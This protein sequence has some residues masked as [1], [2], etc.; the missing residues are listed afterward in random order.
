M[1]KSAK[2][3][4][5]DELCRKCDGTGKLPQF[6]HIEGGK[7]FECGGTGE[8]QQL[9][10]WRA[11]WRARWSAMMDDPARRAQVFAPVLTEPTVSV[12]HRG[13]GGGELYVSWLNLETE[14]AAK[15]RRALLALPDA[16]D[17]N[18]WVTVPATQR[19]ALWGT[20]KRHAAGVNLRVG[21]QAKGAL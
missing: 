12:N 8:R 1:T 15:L 11:E 2:D 18:L 20:L 17:A 19:R 21:M 5:L 16:V 9:A 6:N 13:H 14:V 4:G 7:C 10:D 3:Q